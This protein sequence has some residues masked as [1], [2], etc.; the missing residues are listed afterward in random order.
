MS[1]FNEPTQTP[2]L[3]DYLEKYKDEDGIAKAI[4]E[5]DSFIKRLETEQAE[6]RRELQTRTPTVD[7][8]QEILDRME[9]LAQKNADTGRQAEPL[10]LERSETNTLTTA[11][12]ER[13]LEQREAK[14]RAEANVAA[15]KAKLVEKYGD[16]Y[17]QAL[18]TIA[19]SNGLTAKDLDELAARSPQLIYNLLPS[20][21]KDTGF[22]P[23]G[24]SL[25]PTGF[26]PTADGHKPRSHYEKLKATD[27][28]KYFSAEVQSQMYKDAMALKEA[29]EA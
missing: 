10:P 7:R 8:T 23:P 17:G 27:K 20:G 16:N 26:V 18:K 2:K 21:S 25:S 29:F 12:I 11:D 19:D 9:A 24:S 28:V 3:A 14:K 5:K 13:V 1:L 6:L 15:V 22:V 4:S